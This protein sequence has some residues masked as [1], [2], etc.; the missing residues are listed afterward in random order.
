MTEVPRKKGPLPRVGRP[1]EANDKPVERD[2]MSG[3]GTGSRRRARFLA[4]F[5]GLI[6]AVVALGACGLQDDSSEVRDLPTKTAESGDVTIKATPI[7]IGKDDAVFTLSLVSVGAELTV[8]FPTA[9]TLTVDGVAWKPA[10]W[11]GAASGGRSL[12]GRLEFRALG[13]ARD[14]AVLRIDGLSEPVTLTWT[15]GRAARK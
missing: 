9:A 6:M 3:T 12:E 15:F 8:A 10:T 7:R 2:N 1:L 13:T 14:R 4:G 5:A 11:D